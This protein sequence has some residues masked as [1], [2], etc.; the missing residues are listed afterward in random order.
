MVKSK[1]DVSHYFVVNTWD[2]PPRIYLI[3]RNSE[4][5]IDLARIDIPEELRDRFLETVG[6]N[7]GIYAI[8]QEVKAWLEKEL[9]G[10]VTTQH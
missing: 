5:A 8:N 10:D 4:E 6:H 2:D 7:K 3:R 9:Y 1:N